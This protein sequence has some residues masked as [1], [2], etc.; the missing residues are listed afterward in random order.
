MTEM[1]RAHKLKDFLTKNS[2]TYI[3]RDEK[4]EKHENN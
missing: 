3:K 4:I 1:R 2:I